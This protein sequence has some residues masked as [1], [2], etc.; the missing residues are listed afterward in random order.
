MFKKKKDIK[1]RYYIIYIYIYIYK[2]KNCILMAQSGFIYVGNITIHH[3]KEE[4]L[5]WFEYT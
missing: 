1:E 4:I 3:Y 5:I 2:K